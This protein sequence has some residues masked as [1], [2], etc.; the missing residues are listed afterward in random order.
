MAEATD[1]LLGLGSE[2][3]EIFVQNT[4]HTIERA[5]D[6]LDTTVVQS[7]GDNSLDASINYGGGATGLAYQN[8][9]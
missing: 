6:L 7:L 2:I 1:S 3:D 9:T 5:V 8:V 4:E